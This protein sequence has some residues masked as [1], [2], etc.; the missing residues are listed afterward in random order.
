MG[1][2]LL[3]ES[4]KYTKAGLL[5]IPISSEIV[6]GKKTKKPPRGSGSWTKHNGRIYD[7]AY[8]E[9]WFAHDNNEVEYLAIAMNSIKRCIGLDVDSIEG[10]NVF[11][12]KILS[13][14][15]LPLQDKINKTAHTKTPSG[16]F[17]WI[18]EI[19]REDF[20]H[21]INSKDLWT[22]PYA[23]HSEIKLFGTAK[24]LIERGPGY[25]CIRDI[26]CLQSLRNDDLT[27]CYRYVR[28]SA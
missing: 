4:E 24:Y 19:S 9:R 20:P 5:T 23:S 16:G 18:F 22:S 7:R 2:S 1:R 17:H 26:D 13:K 11:I 21:E 8:R 14:L 6:N 12:N 27:S 3:D 15:S 28:D 25:D 10:F